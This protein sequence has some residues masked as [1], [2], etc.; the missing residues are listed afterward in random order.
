MPCYQPKDARLVLSN[1]K[2]D[3]GKHPPERLNCGRCHGCKREKAR[4]WTIRLRHE[5]ALHE[6]AEAITLT[7]N[8]NHLPDGNQL[9]KKHFQTFLKRLRFQS[10]S[11]F[12]YFMCGEYGETSTKRPHYHCVFFGLDF[13]DRYEWMHTGKSIQ[14]RSPF[15]ETLWRHGFATTGEVDRNTLSYISGYVQKKIYGAEFQAEYFDRVVPSTGEITQEARLPPYSQMSLRPGI[16]RDWI[17]KYHREVYPSDFIVLDGHRF[18]P[19]GYYDRWLSEH[20][21]ELWD[22]VRSTRAEASAE[23]PKESLKRLR[24]KGQAVQ[25]KQARFEERT[26]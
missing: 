18:K 4:Q 14:Y 3:L 1:A 10:G 26:L 19:P 17:E 2:H 9:V 21:P 22:Q 15:L 8:D 11:S 16:A 25:S 5:H 20:D 7:Y 23:R 24:Q 6:K 13:A 12:R